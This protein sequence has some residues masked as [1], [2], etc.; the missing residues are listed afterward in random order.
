MGLGYSW[1]YSWLKGA[2]QGRCADGLPSQFD[3]CIFLARIR[4]GNASPEAP[5]LLEPEGGSNVSNTTEHTMEEPCPT[6]PSSN[7]PCQ[8]RS[9]QTVLNTAQHQNSLEQWEQRIVAW[10]ILLD[11]DE[12]ETEPT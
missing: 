12:I 5:A 11:Q 7:V 1:G 2:C 4:T 8:T 6:T 3:F 10:E 9:G